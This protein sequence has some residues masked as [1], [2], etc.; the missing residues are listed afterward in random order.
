M[1]LQRIE[2]LQQ[3]L[4]MYRLRSTQSCERVVFQMS[5]WLY[6]QLCATGIDNQVWL[7][8]QHRPVEMLTVHN[9][10]LVNATLR[11]LFNTSTGQYRL[12]ILNASNS[13]CV[14]IERKL[15]SLLS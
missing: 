9:Y 14:S 4:L 1:L 6:I 12:V 8:F 5:V 15:S 13:V 10:H 3:G 11:L 2:Q 7:T